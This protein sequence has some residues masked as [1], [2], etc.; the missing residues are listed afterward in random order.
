MTEV[1]SEISDLQDISTPFG[2]PLSGAY[3]RSYAYVSIKDRMPIILTK[4]I[5]TICQKKN[6][7]IYMYG[8]D[9]ANDIKNIIGFISR[10]KN[11]IVTNKTL[12]PMRLNTKAISNDAEEWNTYLENKTQVESGI[13]TWFNTTWLYCETYMYRILAQEIGLTSS[14]Q[15]YDPFEYIKQ[16]AFVNCIDSM[17]ILASYVNDIVCNKEYNK[18]N[19]KNDFS[20]LLKL[21]LWGN[22][23]DLSASVGSLQEH[24]NNVLNM[25]DSLDENILVNNWELV[26][27]IVK[28]KTNKRVDNIHIVLDNAGCEFFSDLC[29]AAFLVTIAPATK[30]TFHVKAYPWYVSDTTVQ[31][32]HWTL[33][34]LNSLDH[35]P[36]MKLMG[37]KFRNFMDREIWCIKAEPYWTGPYDFRQMKEKDKKLYAQFSDAKLVIFKGD[38][39]Y[40]KLLSDINFEYNTNFATALGDFRPTNILS[41]RTLKSD[42]CV[43]LSQGM[44]ESLFE[45]NKDWL[46]TGEY[47]LIQIAVSLEVP[48]ES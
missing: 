30:I 38:L 25:A 37:K 5:D 14:I 4:V 19:S 24:T 10:L 45:K 28:E 7:I 21:S 26:W 13:P 40:R 42:I 33:D 47:G 44:V 3:K 46:I 12:K 18:E 9:A 22:R 8:Q 39:N 17:N 36:N 2:I 15:S 34:H 23:Y 31:D 16:A 11:E 20:R 43:G 48:E 35:Y 27:N 32:F 1:N 29:L 41:I 6:E